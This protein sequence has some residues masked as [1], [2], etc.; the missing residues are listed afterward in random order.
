MEGHGLDSSGTGYGLVAGSLEHM[1]TFRF[2]RMLAIY[3]LTK[4]LGIQER[5]INPAVTTTGQKLNV[6]S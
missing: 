5:E 1:R 4:Q 6:L 2:H 3:Q